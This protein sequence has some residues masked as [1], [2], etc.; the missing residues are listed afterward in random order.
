MRQSAALSSAT[1]HT[2]SRKSGDSWEQRFYLI[3][4][5]KIKYILHKN[6]IKRNALSISAQSTPDSKMADE[7]EILKASRKP[8]N[9]KKKTK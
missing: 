8:L 5:A 1:Q 6:C 7:I 2:I 9:K 4:K 3:T